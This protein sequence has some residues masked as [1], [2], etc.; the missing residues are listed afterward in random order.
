M[1]EVDSTYHEEEEEMEGDDE[2]ENDDDDAQKPK[3][4]LTPL[5]KYVTRLGGGTTKFTY[6][7]L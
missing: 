7:P 5:W 4:I 6:P 2:N 3:K 1:I